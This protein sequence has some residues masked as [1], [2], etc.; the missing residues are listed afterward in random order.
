MTRSTY[1][2]AVVG[3]TVT[4]LT[5]C[6]PCGGAASGAVAGFYVKTEG[7][8]FDITRAV[9]AGAANGAIAQGL[10]MATGGDIFISTFL[11]SIAGGT[12]SAAIQGG[13]I[14]QGA[15]VGAAI[16]AVSAYIQYS[17]QTATSPEQA[18]LI[19]GRPKINQPY[20]WIKAVKWLLMIRE[21]LSLLL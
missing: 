20:L 10:S 13:N 7:R 4:M 8:D 18:Q 16:G 15:I 11:G 12:A 5:G 6:A 17:G 2:S 9:I 3:G 1:N 21:Y 14:A 19:A